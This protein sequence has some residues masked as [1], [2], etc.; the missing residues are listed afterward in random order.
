M[1]K[2]I[3][4][5]IIAAIVIIIIISSWSF[6]AWTEFKYNST[7]TYCESDFDCV[8][9]NGCGCNNFLNTDIECIYSSESDI[10]KEYGCK[11][12]SNN[13]IALPIPAGDID[14]EQEALMFA[15]N[16]DDMKGFIDDNSYMGMETYAYYNKYSGY[17]SVVSSVTSANDFDWQLV[18]YPNGTIVNSGTIPF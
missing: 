18:F 4:I 14:S 15:L 1:N 10:C 8:C 7:L 17:W 6:L 9:V 13:C 2:K 11:C 3:K 16:N 5:E 12:V